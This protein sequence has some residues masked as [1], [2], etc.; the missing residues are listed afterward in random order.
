[1]AIVNGD[2]QSGIVSFKIWQKF[3]SNYIKK[4]LV[5]IL[6]LKTPN[7]RQTKHTGI[8]WAK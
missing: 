3:V 6:K 4:Q 8:M 1:M 7:D 5:R 2:V